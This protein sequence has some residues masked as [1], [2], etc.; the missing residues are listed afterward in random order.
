MRVLTKSVSMA[1]AAVLEPLALAVVKPEPEDEDEDEDEDADVVL[2]TAALLVDV[3]R[4]S[5]LNGFGD[6]DNEGG[7][8]EEEED[9]EEEN[10]SDGGDWAVPG[11]ADGVSMLLLFL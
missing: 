1:L 6:D 9:T 3:S 11:V 2:D 7:M 8:W 5:L 4:A 10:G